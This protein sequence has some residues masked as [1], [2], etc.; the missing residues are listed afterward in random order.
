[1]L[2]IYTDGGASLKHK[3]AAAGIWVPAVNY[4]NV[5]LI[6]NATNN[7]AELTAFI[8]A[9]QYALKSSDNDITI[10]ADS[11]YVLDGYNKNMYS[12]YPNI[13]ER[14]N[15]HLWQVLWNLKETENAKFN[16][17]HCRGHGK[18]TNDSQEDVENNHIVDRMVSEAMRKH[19]HSRVKSN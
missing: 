6:E 7:F 15:G 11:L 9:L 13:D 10:V 2:T 12:W 8:L 19:V 5:L 1:M 16:T 18:G 14:V 4:S 3:I 17:R